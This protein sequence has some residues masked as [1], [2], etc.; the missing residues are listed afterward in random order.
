[1]TRPALLLRLEALLVLSASL[2]FYR[3]SL[4][5]HW[6]LF[7]LLFLA[8]DISLAGYLSPSKTIA[9]AIYNTVHSY[10]LALLVGFAAWRTSHLLIGQLAAICIAHIA[11]DRLLGYGLKFPEAFRP[12]H[13]QSA[14]V[15][16]SA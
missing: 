9:A 10:I 14:A 8:P 11:F 12:T 13:I 15:F 5:G 16:R 2:L 7:A 3:V 1:M 4:H 6:L